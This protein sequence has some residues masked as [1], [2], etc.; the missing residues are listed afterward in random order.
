MTVLSKSSKS[1]SY[2]AISLGLAWGLPGVVE[3]I[4]GSCCVVLGGG[5]LWSEGCLVVK[6]AD[7]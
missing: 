7:N 5:I 6:V 2:W 3:L 1:V 4:N